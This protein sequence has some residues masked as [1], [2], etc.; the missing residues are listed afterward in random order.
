[1]AKFSYGAICLINLALAMCTQRM[2]IAVG[3]ILYGISILFFLLHLYQRHKAGEQFFI[4]KENKQYFKVYGLFV[5]L[6][7]PSVIFS[8]DPMYSL[9]IPA[10]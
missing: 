2:L 3:N 7:L 9:S 4:S 10:A 5:L 6:L 8:I 1:M